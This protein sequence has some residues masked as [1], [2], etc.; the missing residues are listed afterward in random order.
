MTG[1]L[2]QWTLQKALLT[3][4]SVI[5]LG[6]GIFAVVWQPEQRDRGSLS[7]GEVTAPLLVTE[8]ADFT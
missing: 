3:F 7:K 8:Y 6:A 5:A 4:I 1:L 2:M